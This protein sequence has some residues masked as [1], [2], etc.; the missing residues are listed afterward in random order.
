MATILIL[1]LV[2]RVTACPERSR[3]G[4]RRAFGVSR[5]IGTRPTIVGI[6][7]DP[8]SETSARLDRGASVPGI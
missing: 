5:Q 2:G 8:R 1:V 7:A 3:M 4:A 6:K